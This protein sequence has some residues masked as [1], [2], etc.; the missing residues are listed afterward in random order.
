VIQV[1][2]KYSN[3]LGPDA[4]AFIQDILTSHEIP[5]HLLESSIETLAREYNKQDGESLPLI[6]KIK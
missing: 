6:V 2:R 5:E 3:S 4:I 1:F